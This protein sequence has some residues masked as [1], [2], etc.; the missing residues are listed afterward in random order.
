[1]HA[2]PDAD[3]LLLLGLI[4]ARVAN[5]RVFFG[6]RASVAVSG[7]AFTGPNTDSSTATAVT[8]L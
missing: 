8:A 3:I 5:A 7:M 4:S 2:A 1:V 6:S